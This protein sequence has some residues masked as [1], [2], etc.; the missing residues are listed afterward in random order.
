MTRLTGKLTELFN[1]SHKLEK[2]IKKNIG[3]LGYEI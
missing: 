1:Q 3:A 2:E